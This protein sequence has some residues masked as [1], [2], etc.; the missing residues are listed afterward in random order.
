MLE[1]CYMFYMLYVLSVAPR[2]PKA[3][4]HQKW[5]STTISF[6]ASDCPDNM[7]EGSVLPLTLSLS[8]PQRHQ[9]HSI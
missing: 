8:L 7:V 3:A 4:P 2:A 9:T 1:C 5:R 6:G